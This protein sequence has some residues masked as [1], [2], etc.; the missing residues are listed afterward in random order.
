MRTP[1]TIDLVDDPSTRKKASKII[2]VTDRPELALHSTSFDSRD[3]NTK[4]FS[5]N[6]PN[7]PSYG[8]NS[9]QVFGNRISS[10]SVVKR[11]RN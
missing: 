2:Q 7:S 8:I 5:M 3:Y 1:F 11:W 6:Q 4:A 10:Q 9:P